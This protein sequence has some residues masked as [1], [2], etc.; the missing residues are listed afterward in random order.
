MS[1]FQ[2]VAKATIFI[3]MNNVSGMGTSTGE[4]VAEADALRKQISEFRGAYEAV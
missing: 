4:G 3:L 2:G 1:E